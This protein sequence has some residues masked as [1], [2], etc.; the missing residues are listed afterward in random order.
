[1]RTSLVSK[2]RDLWSSRICERERR[3]T[4][5]SK[6]SSNYV[7]KLAAYTCYS[8]VLFC[9]SCRKC[10][11][12]PS[13]TESDSDYTTYIPTTSSTPSAEEEKVLLP[14]F[15]PDA[16][17]SDDTWIWWWYL[18]LR[19]ND[20]FHDFFT[21]YVPFG[22]EAVLYFKEQEFRKRFPARGRPRDTGNSIKIPSQSGVSLEGF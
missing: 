6:D 14:Q 18:L 19:V 10:S 9:D 13:I 3:S 21:E 16:D 2:T 20:N 7:N 11:P 4:T 5:S 15:S 1:M 22:E 8:D 17:S 12:Y